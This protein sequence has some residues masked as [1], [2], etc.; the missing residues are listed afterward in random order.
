MIMT[1]MTIVSDGSGERGAGR[2]G[3]FEFYFLFS[4]RS[5]P[6]VFLSENT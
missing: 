5:K 2:G 1:M 3:G 4:R 6:R